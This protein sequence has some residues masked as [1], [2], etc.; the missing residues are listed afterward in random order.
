MNKKGFFSTIYASFLMLVLTISALTILSVDAQTVGTKKTYAVCGILPNPVGVGQETLI[1]LGISDAVAWPKP[2]WDDLTVTVTRP[3]G[4]NETLGPFRTDTTGSTGTSY[5]PTV[6]GNYTIQT[7][8]PAQWYNYSGYDFSSQSYVDKQ[9]YYEASDSAPVIL[10]VQEDPIPYYPGTP[11]PTEYWSR[12]INAQFFEWAPITGNWLRP[13][14]FGFMA[15]T[16]PGNEQS[17]DAPHILW[18]KQLSEGGLVGEPNGVI[19]YETGDAYEGKFSGSVIINGVLYYNK[20]EAEGSSSV[21]QEVVAVDLK[22]GEEL[23]TNNWNNSRLSFGQLF[24]FSS[25][26]YHG[27]FAYLWTSSSTGFF[28]FGPEN[29]NAY[30]ALTGRWIYGIDNIPSGTNIYGENGEIY[31]YTVDTT[32]GYL[33]MWNSTLV[34]HKGLDELSLGSWRPHGQVYDASR[35]IQWNKTITKGLPGSSQQ[36]LDDRI[37]GANIG[38]DTITFWALSLKDG[39]EG[40]LLYNKTWNPPSGNLTFSFAAASSEDKVFVLSAKET[41]NWYG[42]S[43]ETGALLW[44]TSQPQPDLDMYDK[45][46]ATAIGY[47][48]F[49]SAHYGGVVHCYDL[50]TGDLLW[51]YQAKDPYGEILW[52]NNWPLGIDFLTDGKI[53]VSYMEHKPLNPNGRGAPFICLNATSGDKIWEMNIA[54]TYWGGFAIIGD[55]IITTYNG[56]DQRIYAIGKGPSAITVDAPAAGIDLGRSLVIRGQVTDISPGISDYALTSRFPNGVPVMS[57]ESMQTWMEYVYMQKAR[58]TNVT[59]VSILLTVLDANGNYREIGTTTSDSN[60]Y[61]NL[62]WTPDISGKYTVFATFAGSNSY[63]PSTA[64]TAFAV[65]ETSM[66]PTATPQT[67]TSVAE[68]YFIPT[69][70]GVIIAFA[71]VIALLVMLLLRKRP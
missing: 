47:G 60:G 26:N 45:W 5:T 67:V 58:P 29:W 16:V 53:C 51:T 56:Y 20:Y 35:G 65:E 1:W 43:T 15:Q 64:Q 37:L 41:L 33:S 18:T 69:V 62:E 39:Q 55:N 49:Y 24:S 71:I 36:V 48:N 8:F 30:D 13:G 19:G 22:S 32:N 27:T 63:Y 3:D 31:R 2:G 42:F 68:T 59:G 44:T 57:D 23:W 46:Y 17:P 70:I 38:S 11:L 10:V 25:H 40:T 4:T 61:Y 7:H 54:G 14:L 9:T 50:K 21:T 52:S 6:V 28:S 12:P 66:S 34:V